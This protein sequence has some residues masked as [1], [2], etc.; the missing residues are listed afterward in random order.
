MH[1][2]KKITPPASAIMPLEDVALD[3]MLDFTPVPR[4]TKRWNG[5]TD[6]KQR[7][8]IDSLAGSGCVKMAS[9]SI[10]T[11]TGAMYQLRKAEGA[12]SFAAAWDK[13]VEAGARIVLDLLMAHAIHG[14]PETLLKGGEVILERRKY[15][16]RAMMWIV[17]QRFP[18]QYGG[19]L[20]VTGNAPNSMPHGIKKLKDQWRKEWEE[21]WR[22]EQADRRGN[23]IASLHNKV[24]AIRTGFK[25]GIAHDPAKRAAWELLTGPADWSD[26]DKP[27]H[28]AGLPYDFNMNRPDV[29]VPL[30]EGGG[31]RP[32]D[33]VAPNR[34]PAIVRHNTSKHSDAMETPRGIPPTESTHA[35][36]A[37]VPAA[38]HAC[39]TICSSVES[40]SRAGADCSVATRNSAESASATAISIP[41][42]WPATAE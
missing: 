38:H 40:A 10:G 14:T 39:G 20:N 4:A 6:Q 23:S 25:R 28:Y 29:I 35:G 16:T 15:N 18:E 33:A 3:P 2:T 42:S 8:F 34:S 17:Q 36:D 26:F 31:P 30:A 19:S 22:A 32:D 37:D 11:S 7:V 9:N 41:E 1:M 5:I 13:A 24:R 12:E 21:E 27:A